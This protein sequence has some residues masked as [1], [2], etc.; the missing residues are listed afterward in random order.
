MAKHRHSLKRFQIK[1]NS[2]DIHPET[3]RMRD[4]AEVLL[5]IEKGLSSIIKKNTDG[6][7]FDEVGA[8]LVSIKPGCAA[9]ELQSIDAASEATVRP[10]MTHLV[11]AIK[12]RQI[13]TLPPPAQKTIEAI[14]HFSL[15]YQCKTEFRLHS[16]NKNPNAVIKPPK[17]IVLAEAT[18]LEGETTIYGKVES[19]GGVGT[20]TVW[21]RTPDNARIQLVV[22]QKDAPKFG[23]KLY[24]WIGIKGNACWD[25]KANS[26][27]R[28]KM[29]EIVKYECKPFAEAMEELSKQLEGFLKEV[30]DVD[31]IMSE[32]RGD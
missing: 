7:I 29:K 9:L 5:N 10:A 15:R 12:S 3:I 20:P 19:A 30:D 26:I 16:T 28:F 25:E 27:I 17:K 13:E 21:I 14:E 32:I 31:Q 23:E 11:R 1:F 2:K 4:L 24:Q 18:P 22:S 8:S 6:M